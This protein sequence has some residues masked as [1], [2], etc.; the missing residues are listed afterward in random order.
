MTVPVLIILDGWG[1]G[2]PGPYNAIHVANTPVWDKYWS[3]CPTSLLECSGECVGLPPGQMGNSEVGH[4]T[5]GAGRIID[6][7]F[8]RINKAIEDGTFAD[9]TVLR[10]LVKSRESSHVHVM[11]LCSPGGVHS[12]EEQIKF[13]LDLLLNVTSN[14]SVH[15]FLDGRD[16]PPKSARESLESFERLLQQRTGSGV[17]SIT[18][19]Y[20]AMDRDQRWERTKLTFD[21]L[22]EPTSSF[23]S[24]SAIAALEES[25]SQCETD[26]FVQPMRT[27]HFVPIADGDVVIFMNFRADRARQLTSAFVIDEFVH[28]K[29]AY[30]PKL[31]LYNVNTVL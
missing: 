13:L 16:T 26:E 1:H 30:C 21:M 12:H 17:A 28:F 10:Q 6:Q 15:C 31:S 2:E 22:T 19:R 5:M 8:T 9:L 4:M 14:V 20:Y 7:D 24:T 29:R 23:H 18:G 11:G 25:Y 3:T 27:R